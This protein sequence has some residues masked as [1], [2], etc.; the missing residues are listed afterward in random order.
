MGL[1]LV[2]PNTNINFVG[3]RK[4]AFILSLSVILIGLAS[5][6]FK[7]GLKYG[8]DFAGGIVVQVRFQQGIEIEELKDALVKNN[9]HGISV[10][11][12]G[13]AAENEYLLRSALTGDNTSDKFRTQVKTVLDAQY[14]DKYQIQRMEM[15]GP[16]VGADL[17]SKALEAMF[18]SVLLI[19]IYISGRFEKRWWTAGFMAAGLAGGLYILQLFSLPKEYLV[20][21]AMLITLGLC[22]YLK[23]SYALGAITALIHDVLITVGIFSVLDKEFDLT[24]VAALLTIIGYSLNDTIIIF[25][26]VRSNLHSKMQGMLLPQIINKSVNQT[27]SRTLLTSGTTLTVVLVLFFF[28]GSVIHDFSLALLLGVIIGTYSSIYIASTILLGFGVKVE[29]ETP[30]KPDAVV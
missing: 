17:R 27:L 10:Q 28:G 22:W 5:L 25:D 9:V 29:E 2:S 4:I 1:Q 26:R 30:Q 6:V 14:G 23:L 24:I 12:F 15:V 19:A 21:A 8:I 18:Y 11:Q 13:N 3:L 7:G 16:K 20:V